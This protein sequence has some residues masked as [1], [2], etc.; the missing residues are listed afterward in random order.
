MLVLVIQKRNQEKFLMELAWRLTKT[1]LHLSDN[2]AAESQQS[3][4]F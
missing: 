3:S 2:Q 1:K 4:N